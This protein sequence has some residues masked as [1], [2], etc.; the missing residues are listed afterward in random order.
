[1]REIDFVKPVTTAVKACLLGLIALS[2][3]SSG[4]AEERSLQ[5]EVELAKVTGTRLS[6]AGTVNTTEWEASV[7]SGKSEILDHVTVTCRPGMP[8]LMHLGG[9]LP[10]PY[11]DPRVNGSQV[12]YVD[13]GLTIDTKVS[14]DEGLFVIDS[15]V[16]SKK[17]NATTH[18]Y[19]VQDVIREQTQFL[20]APSQTAIIS[21]VRGQFDLATLNRLYPKAKFGA[22][23]SLVITLRVKPAQ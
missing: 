12:Q 7:D 5:V 6:H 20:L 9:K 23:D 4:F 8:N 16:S 10:I 3:T 22:Q 14:L 21:S 15:S 17:Q 11:F 18:S 13:D 2:A 19:P 1:M